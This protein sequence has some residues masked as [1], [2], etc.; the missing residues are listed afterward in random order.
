MLEVKHSFSAQS[1]NVTQLSDLYIPRLRVRST[2]KLASIDQQ[3]ADRAHDTSL[4][5]SCKLNLNSQKKTNVQADAI[6]TLGTVR[7]EILV[8]LMASIRD[9]KISSRPV[10]RL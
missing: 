7:S 3:L 6:C 4:P 1:R 5:S 2:S 9:C 10:N 8:A